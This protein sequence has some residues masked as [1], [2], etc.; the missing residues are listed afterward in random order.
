MREKYDYVI[1]DTPPLGSVI[2]AAIVATVSDGAVLVIAANQVSYKFAQNVMDQLRK[3]K[4]K[5]IGSVLNK[6]D[7]SENGTME[8]TMVNITVNTTEATMETIIV[9]NHQISHSKKLRQKQQ[10]RIQHQ[11]Q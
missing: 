8:S 9:M 1:I 4:V 6:V 3:T 2:D 5:I 11:N 7:L 10:K